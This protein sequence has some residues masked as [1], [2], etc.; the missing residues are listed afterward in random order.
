MSDMEFVKGKLITTGLNVEAFMEVHFPNW[1]DADL[2][3]KEAFN[4][5]TTEKEFMIIK[6]TVYR[7]LEYVELDPCGHTNVEYNADGT[8][9]FV[10]LWYNGGA[11]LNETIEYSMKK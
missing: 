2:D 4:E 7:V 9:D 10:S 8:I 6:G 3:P 1:K 5:L 11:C